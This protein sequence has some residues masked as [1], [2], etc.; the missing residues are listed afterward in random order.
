MADGRCAVGDVGFYI[1]RSLG[2]FL[3]RGVWIVVFQPGV[4]G[5]WGLAVSAHQAEAVVVLCLAC[6]EFGLVHFI[7][8]GFVAGFELVAEGFDVESSFGVVFYAVLPSFEMNFVE[9]G[10]VFLRRRA[11]MRKTPGIDHI[12]S[13]DA[14]L[15]IPKRSAMI[16]KFAHDSVKRKPASDKAV[17]HRHAVGMQVHEVEIVAAAAFV[18]AAGEFVPV[19]HAAGEDPGFGV[20][21][22]DGGVGEL[23]HLGVHFAAL[24]QGDFGLVC[25]K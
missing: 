12:A 4:G 1:H 21:S 24:A 7:F 17:K 18:E 22:L 10:A 2:R 15:S 5:S 6:G 25:A 11:T 14:K 9:I 23:E 16:V 8:G 19:G 20:G 3:D 13:V